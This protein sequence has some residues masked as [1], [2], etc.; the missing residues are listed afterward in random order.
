MIRDFFN[1]RPLRER[2]LLVSF[3]TVGIL[4]WLGMLIGHINRQFSRTQ[5]AKQQL[6]LQEIL[7][8]N[9]ESVNEGLELMKT[10]MDANKTLNGTLL[11]E[12]V[13]RHARDCNMNFDISSPVQLDGDIFKTN[14]VRISIRDTELSSLMLMDQKIKQEA[15][16]LSL[17]SI[18][19]SAN[20]RDP[21]K[22]N[23][24]MEISSFEFNKAEF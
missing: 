3:L 13:D 14:T 16:Y 6:E 20:R 23:A 18:Q 8:S 4:I 22:L 7:F 1:L 24:V 5:D 21:R 11:I 9:K 12:R 19:I 10:V 2:Y 17:I 15:P